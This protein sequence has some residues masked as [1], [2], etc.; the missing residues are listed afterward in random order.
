MGAVGVLDDQF[1]ALVI[2]WRRQEQRRGQVGAD[3]MSRARHM[4]DR[5]VDMTAEGLPLAV[6]VEHRRQDSQR[7]GR[8]DEQRMAL[9]RGDDELAGLAGERRVPGQ[10]QVLLGARRLAPGRRASVNPL[11]R[12]RVAVV[13]GRSGRRSGRLE[14]GSACGRCVLRPSLKVQPEYIRPNG[15]SSGIVR[16]RAVFRL[17]FHEVDAFDSIADGHA[18]SRQVPRELARRPTGDDDGEP[19]TPVRMRRQRLVRAQAGHG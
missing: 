8:R 19:A 1:A 16:Q 13:G 18:A 14:S 12:Q 4:P 9:E 3:P 5:V 17:N 11:G 7:Q 15:R 2:L 6:A 10:L